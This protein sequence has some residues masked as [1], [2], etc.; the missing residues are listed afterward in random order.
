MSRP[1]I[2]FDAVTLLEQMNYTAEGRRSVSLPSRQTLLL[3][4][5][6]LI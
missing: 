1:I 2:L 6:C 5:F 3:I 4:V